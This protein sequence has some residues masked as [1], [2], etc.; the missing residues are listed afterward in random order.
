[1]LLNEAQHP[2][3]VHGKILGLAWAGWLF[4]FYDLLLFSF[5]AIPIEQTLHLSTTQMSLLLGVSLAA[6]AAGGVVFGW[7]ADRIGRK[8]VL[9]LTVGTYSVGTF[10]C[11]T[12][13][14]FFDLLLYRIITGFGVGGEWGTGQ[15]LVAETFPTALRA[16]AAALMQTGAPCGVALAALV[17]GFAEPWFAGLWG[18]D[19]A[20]RAGFWISVL[21]V[22]MILVIRVRMPES[23]VW[24][25]MRA[26]VSREAAAQPCLASCLR[27]D[28]VLRRL[29]IL[30]LVLA[31]SDMSAYW[32]TYVWLPK[33]LYD[34]LGLSLAKS[35]IWMLVT[36]TGG[37]LGYVTF[38]MVA[39]WRGRRIAYTLYSLLWAAALLSVTW[40]WGALAATPAVL[41]A[42]MF[43]VGVGTGNFSGYGP[44]LAELFPTAIRNSAMGTAFNVARGIQFFTPLIIT[45]IAVLPVMQ[46]HG[47][48]AGI[49]LGGFFALFTALW[50][51]CLPETR[52][53][54]ITENELIRPDR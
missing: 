26:A 17:G 51:W 12:S 24:L 43:F 37:L 31:V 8:P 11:G 42:C 15:T 47:L 6:T 1:M 38:G 33:Y 20:W 52:G 54:R 44:I 16:R 34:Q 9:M 25:A 13:Q 29:F 5:L 50:V 53:V 46:T 45:W 36:Q 22:V 35:G 19:T 14:G 4:D 23:D 18:A 32:Y 3:R 27:T 41:L 39:D 48:G 28:G 40:F 2:T 49:S 7:L 30:G 21:P 10:L